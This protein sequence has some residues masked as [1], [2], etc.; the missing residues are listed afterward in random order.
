[1][2][3][4][5]QRAHHYCHILRR[6]EDEISAAGNPTAKAICLIMPTIDTADANGAWRAAR[7]SLFG[8]ALKTAEPHV[9]YKMTQYDQKDK[10]SFGELVFFAY[11]LEPES[12]PPQISIAEPLSDTSLKLFRRFHRMDHLPLTSLSGALERQRA[13]GSDKCTVLAYA[14]LLRFSPATASIRGPSRMLTL[15]DGAAIANIALYN[16]DA[17]YEPP[18]AGSPVVIPLYLNG[19]GACSY[20]G[21]LMAVPSRADKE[22]KAFVH[23]NESTK[24]AED[25]SRD[26][27]VKEASIAIDKITKETFLAIAPAEVQRCSESRVISSGGKWKRQLVV[28]EDDCKIN[29]MMMGKAAENVYRGTLRVGEVK[30]LP[31]A[32]ESSRGPLALVFI[33]PTP[34]GQG[35]F[36]VDNVA[37]E[38]RCIIVPTPRHIVRLAIGARFTVERA[39]AEKSGSAVKLLGSDV[40]WKEGQPGIGKIVGL[41]KKSPTEVTGGVWA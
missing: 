13:L 14:V 16:G 6:G 35:A 17:L 27:G 12:S 31:P 39:T 20:K 15:G 3:R 30:V 33:P 9:T 7:V 26:R 4:T 19:R 24:L 32:E 1:M 5:A 23:S 36:D 2:A 21:M 18:C 10:G 22:Y 11:A 34:I 37:A 25:F 29:L 8:R 40:E 38:E 28:A 41:Q